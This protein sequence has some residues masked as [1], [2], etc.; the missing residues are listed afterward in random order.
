MAFLKDSGTTP[1]NNDKFTSFVMDGAT[2]STHSLS[3]VVGQGSKL[4][5]F[6]GDLRMSLV[7]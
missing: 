6:V 1:F 2:I 4:Q 7:M 3:I 5:D